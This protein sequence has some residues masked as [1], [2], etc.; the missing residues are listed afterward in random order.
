M[1]PK[2]YMSEICP[3]ARAVV[4][5]AKVLEL[6]LELKEVQPCKLNQQH[7]IPTLEDSGYVI[8]DSHAIIAFLVGKYGKDDSLYPRDNPR[9]SVIDQRLRFDSGVVSFITK[10]ILNPI[11]YED[12]EKTITDIYTVVEHF[13]DDNNCWIAGDDISIADLSLIPSITSLDVVV[14]IDE[15]QFPKLARWVK[16][17]E[18]MPFYEAN[19][20]GLCFVLGTLHPHWPPKARAPFVLRKSELDKKRILFFETTRIERRDP[21]GSFQSHSSVEQVPQIGTG[22]EDGFDSSTAPEGL[23]QIFMKAPHL[24]RS[25]PSTLIPQSNRFNRFRFDF[26]SLEDTHC[27]AL[28]WSIQLVYGFAPSGLVVTFAMAP[29]V[30]VTI[31]SPSVRATLLTTHAL[32][33]NIE[34]EEIDL[35]NKEQF[36]PSFLK[37]NPQHTVPTLE[38]DDDFVVWDSHVINGYLVDKYGGIDDS[39]YPTDMNERAKVNQKLHFDTELALLS[40]RILK[41][42]LHGG[43][44][45]APQEQ[46]DEIVERYDFLEKFLSVNSH[47]ALGH[48]T[49]ADFSVIATVSTI[50]L[51]VPVDLKK[52]PKIAAWMK[53][54]QALP[55]YA[56]NKN[57]LDK[58][59]GQIAAALEG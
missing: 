2:L 36:K 26:H 16:K 46:V 59:R 42:I 37:L 53:K 27:G 21:P 38:D 23:L 35:S 51:I 11:L 14:P 41:S 40:S 55:Y 30:Y 49:I 50:D 6:T 25:V 56:A 15:K 52:Y 45:S 57:G 44:K 34:M 48:L 18:S 17:A 8:W 31:V 33:I 28:L 24:D 1:R 9:R 43:K 13:F 22:P 7:A 29:R 5:T 47:V 3:S 10:T 39:L 20:K 12:N 19:K 4:L 32:G 58:I 54:M